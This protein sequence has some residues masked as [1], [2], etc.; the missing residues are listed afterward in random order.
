VNKYRRTKRKSIRKNK[1]RNTL[2]R[3]HPKKQNTRQKK[4]TYGGM[5]NPPTS[6]NKQL[7][8]NKKNNNRGTTTKRE[9]QK[10]ITFN[11]KRIPDYSRNNNKFQE[12]INKIKPP[13][14]KRKPA[15]KKKTLVQLL[16]E[17]KDI[18]NE[19]SLEKEFNYTTDDY[20]NDDDNYMRNHN[21]SIQ[22]PYVPPP[23]EIKTSTSTSGLENFN[24]SKYNIEDDP[25]VLGQQS[26]SEQKIKSSN[27][28]ID[29]LVSNSY[30]QDFDEK[31]PSIKSSNSKNNDSSFYE[32]STSITGPTKKKK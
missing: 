32:L 14:K 31:T 26:L 2:R 19:N 7:T 13:N 3:N 28:S 21:L 10:F 29:S 20:N 4:Y 27:N 18:K 11:G 22:D 12:L 5:R 25:L 1:S 16:L 15:I 6:R 24:S 9:T 8:V 23:P 17:P 30:S